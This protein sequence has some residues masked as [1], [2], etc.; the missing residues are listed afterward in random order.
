LEGV[1][2]LFADAAF[3]GPD[4]AGL[5]VG[6]SAVLAILTS[7]VRIHPDGTPR[8]AHLTTNV[9][10]EMG[11]GRA[12]ARSRFTVLQAVDGLPLQPIIAGRYRDRFVE[13]EGR[14]RFLERRV[15]TD[16]IGDV[17]QHLL[18]DPAVLG[19]REA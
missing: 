2:D 4:D 10:V 1:A 7:T 12:S 16:L 6:R 9:A 8:T 18:I 13:G 15:L 3:G 17:R 19:L 5:A 14:W 11:S